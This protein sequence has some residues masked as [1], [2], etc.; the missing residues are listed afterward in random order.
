MLARVHPLV[1][2]RIP[3]EPS[4]EASGRRVVGIE[5]DVRKAGFEAVDKTRVKARLRI[6]GILDRAGFI[7]ADQLSRYAAGFR[8]VDLRAG[9]DNNAPKRMLFWQQIGS[10]ILCSSGT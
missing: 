7:E 10:E 5:A 1:G 3:G 4:V 6:L 9:I 8:D 2:P